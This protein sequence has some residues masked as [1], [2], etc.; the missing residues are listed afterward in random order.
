MYKGTSDSIM[1]WP[2]PNT[3]AGEAVVTI[4]IQSTL[5]WILDRLA[6]AG[7]LK[8]GLVAPLQMPRD[9]H[10]CIC[11]VLSA[12]RNQGIGK[13]FSQLGADFNDD[14]DDLDNDYLVMQDLQRR[15]D[16]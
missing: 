1:I 14:D 6:G 13:D 15:V 7:D 9:A 3:H 4:I 5:T 10:P 11:R 16:A 12:L 2:L 8:K